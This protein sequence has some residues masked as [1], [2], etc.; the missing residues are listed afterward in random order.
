MGRLVVEYRTP[1]EDERFKRWLER[2]L[3]RM[4]KNRK[5]RKQGVESE[6]GLLFGV[7][8]TPSSVHFQTQLKCSQRDYIGINCRSEGETKWVVDR[9]LISDN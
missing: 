8:C 1:E 5:K 3:E 2:D 4:Q 7:M 9:Q 6:K